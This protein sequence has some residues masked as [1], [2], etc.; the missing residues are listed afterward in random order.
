MSKPQ[1]MIGIPTHDRR[2]DIKVNVASQPQIASPEGHVVFTRVRAS[3]LLAN[4]FN[5]LFADAINQGYSH[6][7]L[8]HSDIAPAQGWVDRMLELMG[9][10]DLDILSLISP[11]KD[12]SGRTSTAIDNENLAQS[13]WGPPRLTL[14]EVHNE[15]PEIIT[16]PRLVVNTGCM[17]IKLGGMWMEPNPPCFSINDAFG[18]GPDGKLVALVEPEDWA[19]SRVARD[20]GARI[21]A[22]ALIKLEHIGYHEYVNDEVWGTELDDSKGNGKAAP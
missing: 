17:M 16:H 4:N 6:F 20:R 12:K 14:H 11:F 15:W 10:H 13:T 19:F 8:L 22:T 2:I 9:Q 5:L 18:R 21:G 7:V 1:V 3:S